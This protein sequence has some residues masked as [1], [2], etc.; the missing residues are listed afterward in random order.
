[1]T[2][3]SH[4]IIGSATAKIF[5]LNYILT[6]FGAVLPDLAEMVIPQRMPHRGITHSFALWSAALVLAF[7]QPVTLIRD[8]L[9][10]V[11]VGHLLMDSLTVMGVPILDENSRHITLFGGRLRTASA[12]EFVISG[13]IAFLAFVVFG[14]MQI[15]TGRTSWKTLYQQGIIDR[16]EYNENKWKIL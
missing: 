8:C 1:M 12:G 13:I 5:G 2:W 11:M 10:G 7:I 9:I 6:T 15:D 3:A 14:S 16:K 4:M